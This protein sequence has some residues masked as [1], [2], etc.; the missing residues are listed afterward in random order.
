MSRNLVLLALMFA[1]GWTSVA[2]ADER[3]P[4]KN[5]TGSEQNPQARSG[6]AACLSGTATADLDINNVRARLYNNGGLFWRGGDP[7][8]EVPKGSGVQAIF[9]SGI[10]IGG[11]VGG[12]LR[13]AGADY[14]DWEFWPGP[15]DDAGNAPA[16][17][18]PFDRF[19]N[20]RIAGTE[21]LTFV[22]DGVEE[23]RD[24]PI[25]E[26]DVSD[27]PVDLGAPFF[28][29]NGNGIY[30]PNPDGTGDRPAYI[31]TAV[32]TSTS[33]ITQ[34]A[35]PD[36]QI[37]W[38]MNDKGNAH[39]WSNAQP[40]GLEVR[41][42]AF[43]FATADAIGNTTFYKYQLI[44]K[45]DAPLQDTFLGLWSDPDLG[46]F[47]DDY[48]GSDPDLGL[49]FVYNGDT[50][51][52]GNYGTL[53]P[54]LGYD[55]FQGPLVD[56]DGIDNNG[57][58]VADEPG[59]RI[60][61]ERFVY[62]NNDTEP[63][64]NPSDGDDAYGYLSGFWRDETPITF[65]GDGYNPTDT[66]AE[67]ASFMFPADPPQFWSEY[68]TD[69]IGSTNQ[70]A[71]RRFLMSA[72]PFTL[73]ATPDGALV[74]GLNL[75]N[76]VFG[77]QWS[78]N[79]STAARQPQIA[80][81]RLLEFEN[82]LVQGAFN[83]NFNI[84]RPPAP[85]QLT[86][87]GLDG[88]VVLSWSNPRESN[89][90]QESFSIVSPFASLG[91]SDDTY[92]FEGYR[93]LRYDFLGDQNPEEVVVFDVVNG[94]G[95]IIDQTID[96]ETGEVISGVQVA[97]G[98]TGVQN[99]FVVNN[100]VNAQEY[101][102]AVQAYAFNDASAPLKVFASP[103][104]LGVNLQ[105][106]IPE[107]SGS[108]RSTTTLEGEL[109]PFTVEGFPATTAD[110]AASVIDPGSITGDTYRV[111]FF[112]N[113]TATFGE[114]E[115]APTFFEAG[116]DSL[117]FR[118]VNATDGNVLFDS[119]EKFVLTGTY[120]G[121]SDLSDGIDSDDFPV[122]AEGLELFV[123]ARQPG[124][125]IA[126]DGAGV[127]EISYGGTARCASEEDSEACALY[128]GQT[129]WQTPSAN[130]D[131]YVTADG[132]AGTIDRIEF[133]G[134]L[135]AEPFDY[136]MRFTDACASG[137]CWGVYTLLGG[138]RSDGVA[139]E[140][141]F[142]LWQVREEQDGSVTDVQRLIPLLDA[143]GEEP[144]SSWPYSV[145]EGDWDGTGGGTGD[146]AALVSDILF[147]MFP[148]RPDGYDRLAA[149]ASA[150]GGGNMITDSDDQEDVD[151]TSGSACRN[152]GF[153]IDFCYRNDEISGL[154]SSGRAFI[155]IFGRMQLADQAGDG[156]V[157]PA[158]TVIRIY[159]EKPTTP[160]N[161]LVFDTGMFTSVVEETDQAE[162]ALDLIQIV[163][164]PYRGY[165][166]YERGNVDKIARF[167]NLPDEATIRIFTLGGTLVRTLEK[168]PGTDTIL[169]W[170]L[171]NEAG[172]PVASGMYLIHIEV[173]GVG[174]RVLKFGL[175]QR[176]LQL[177][178]F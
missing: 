172:L 49:G 177:D 67:P 63:N 68:N 96:A 158:G 24:I 84:P 98:D 163:P 30:E 126:G 119:V 39:N 16:D 111:E 139:V 25:Y 108:F 35:F 123:E 90:F 28:D 7:V 41:A 46:D 29:L 120:T 107:Q 137:G 42:Q 166:A 176:R 140:V 75:Q 81:Q 109:I 79:S 47:N 112:Y 156:T 118:I 170:D 58:G 136:E 127:V 65:G 102:F 34:A 78:R 77:I 54:A 142:E 57:N 94:T 171:N 56:K 69:G 62:Y 37:W 115:N 125:G 12:E 144:G 32:E 113:S 132:G 93:I 74:E 105:R 104:Q 18:T 27:W 73:E 19:W 153:Y 162:S 14:S 103:I 59:E 64:G 5:R 135:V 15:L 99:Y 134:A 95:P 110:F 55:F 155:P 8:Y 152:Q 72:G 164:N 106:V 11:Q 167:T 80:S 159:T 53:P 60:A 129:V 82:V 33:D 114:G 89:N 17:C 145:A 87:T 149:D 85:P 175:V 76:I 91:A 151:P 70:P 43:A 133:V 168:V 165:S 50:N 44:Y 131:Y 174:E 6:V 116:G 138:L 92:D 143:V 71:D 38:V 124:S 148:D 40:I 51:D 3:E 23:Q 10:W 130:N 128:G 66:N 83:A 86:A 21:R 173:P 122:F 161:A 141:P 52:E 2:L 157:P 61:M 31:S 169:N 9:A 97:G 1:F 121:Y 48:V 146:P 147:W 22:V 150:A 117:A 45:G 20:V 26:G 160:S 178:T 13:F 36:Q 154:S 101:F 88:K 4:K 100:L